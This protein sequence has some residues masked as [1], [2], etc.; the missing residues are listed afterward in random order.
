[1]GHSSLHHPLD[2]VNFDHRHKSQVMIHQ[3][4]KSRKIKRLEEEEKRQIE[5]MANY[6]HIEKELVEEEPSIET[7]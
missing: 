2:D 5:L 6:P 1:M 3:K 7:Y 4:L